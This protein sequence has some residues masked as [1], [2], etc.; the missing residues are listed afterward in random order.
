MMKFISIYDA[1]MKTIRRGFQDFEFEEDDPDFDCLKQLID[2]EESKELARID[3]EV[4]SS[5]FELHRELPS[6]L[7]TLFRKG[8][9][10]QKNEVMPFGDQDAIWEYKNDDKEMRIL[11]Y[12]E[13]M[14]DTMWNRSDHHHIDIEYRVGNHLIA[15]YQYRNC[16]EDYGR[17]KTHEKHC[18]LKKN[19]KIILKFTKSFLK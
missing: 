18:S 11:K 1:K 3:V 5:M 4:I 12:A 15:E 10:L 8:F 14:W 2:F 17:I 13:R 6:L 9:I 19:G 7:Q 16:V